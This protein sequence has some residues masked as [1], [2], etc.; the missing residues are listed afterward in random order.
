MGRDELVCPICQADVPLGGDEK[1]GDEV[2][3]DYCKAPCIIRGE[4]EDSE[5]WELEE[6]F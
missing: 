2:A 4:A 5:A 6:D 1:P 3:C